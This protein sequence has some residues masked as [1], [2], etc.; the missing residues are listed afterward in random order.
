MTYHQHRRRHLRPHPPLRPTPEHHSPIPRHTPPAR[1]TMA[2]AFLVLPLVPYASTPILGLVLAC[3]PPYLAPALAYPCPISY[4][5]S[6]HRKAARRIQQFSAVEHDPAPSPAPT[7]SL[8]C[9]H[10]ARRVDER[11]QRVRIGPVLT[12]QMRLDCCVAASLFSS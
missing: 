7:H 4:T 9:T 6:R 10:A 5:W 11:A 8:D 2:D 1:S 12:T 3:A